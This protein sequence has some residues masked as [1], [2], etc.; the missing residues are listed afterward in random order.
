MAA[1]IFVVEPAVTSGRTLKDNVDSVVVWAEDAADAKLAAQAI[2]GG[3]DE[4]WDGAT[5][6]AAVVGTAWTGWR[7]HVKVVH[8]TTGAVVVDAAHTMLV[9]DGVDDAAAAMVILLNA[10]AIDNASYLTPNLTIATGS[11]GDDLGDHIV[12]VEFL[13]PVDSDDWR[14]PTISIAGMVG[15]IV[16]EGVSTAALT[17]AL[18]PANAIPVFYAAGKSS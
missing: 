17:V 1:S 16:D 6:T 4:L 13:P 8:P 7:L 18:V 10:S 15:A 3:G 11:G 2:A 12:T 14:D 5:A 9:T